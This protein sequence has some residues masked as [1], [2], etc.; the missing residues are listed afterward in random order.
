M[1]F[2]K[3][4]QLKSKKIV[5]INE[6]DQL[7]DQDGDQNINDT[8]ANLPEEDS[9]EST[10]CVKLFSK[11]FESREM[12]HIYHLQVNGDEGSYAAHMALGTFYAD[13]LELVDQLIEVY[14]GQHGIVEGYDIID[15]KDTKTKDKVEYFEE[16]VSFIKT[17]R[18]CIP[19][20]DTHLQNIVDE[21]V[22]LTY[23]T[24][25]KL[26]FNK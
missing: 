15:T 19:E 22:A 9:P 25:F 6:N 10:G 2:K 1:N 17:E 20:E 18:K 11:L 14:Q 13:V 23:Q 26:K 21:I 16:L 3:F 4:T 24:L 8:K 5:R 12:A 7:V